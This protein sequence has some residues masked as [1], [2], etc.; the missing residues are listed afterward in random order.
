MS[1]TLANVIWMCL[2]LRTQE[3][4]TEGFRIVLLLLLQRSKIDAC[5][6]INFNV[7]SKNY[8]N[9][10]ISPCDT[11]IYDV[12]VLFQGLYHVHAK[13]TMELS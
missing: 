12:T 3:F 5:V 11:G 4:V 10:S 7:E 8:C 1:L 6:G 13:F 9:L 2:N